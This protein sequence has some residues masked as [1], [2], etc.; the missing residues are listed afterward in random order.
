MISVSVPS[1]KGQCVKSDCHRLLGA[2]A[3]KRCQDER[4]RFCGC[5]VISLEVLRIRQI[6]LVD[7]RVFSG[8]RS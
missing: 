4:G 2:G 3:W 1:A 6:V 5:G 8:S 7:G